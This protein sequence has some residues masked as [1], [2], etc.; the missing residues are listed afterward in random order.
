MGIT[1]RVFLGMKFWQKA[2]I[3]SVSVGL[4]AILSYVSFIRPHPG[5]SSQEL[6]V[7]QYGVHSMEWF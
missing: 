2:R 5:K 4:L 7:H 1:Y 6:T 3:I